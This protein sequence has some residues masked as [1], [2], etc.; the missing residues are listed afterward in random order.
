MQ[1]KYLMMIVSLVPLWFLLCFI[2][3]Y[4]NPCQFTMNTLKVNWKNM[5]M[6]RLIRTNS[7]KYSKSPRCLISIYQFSPWCF[8]LLINNRKV[9]LQHRKWLS[10]CKNRD[11]LNL[12]RI[13]SKKTLLLYVRTKKSLLGNFMQS[14][15]Q[16]DHYK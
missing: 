14:S 8:R 12:I 3:K 7:N 5:Q 10:I 9:H 13:V 16:S 15:I 1:P 11:S 6:E 2:W 4:I